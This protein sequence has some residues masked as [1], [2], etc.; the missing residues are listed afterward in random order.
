MDRVDDSLEQRKALG[1]Q[2]DTGTDHNAR[3]VCASQMALHDRPSCFIRTDEADGRLPT[4]V[5]S[6]VSSRTRDRH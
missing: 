6:F 1:R 2:A 4:R 3:V 5:R